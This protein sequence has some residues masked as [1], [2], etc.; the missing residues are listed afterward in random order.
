MKKYANKLKKLFKNGFFFF[1][2]S[3]FLFSCATKNII[4]TRSIDFI[5][6]VWV[7]G[8]TFELG[9]ELGRHPDG[10]VTPISTVMLKGFYISIYPVTQEQYLSV[11]G[12]N[13]SFFTIANGR[14]PATGENDNRRPV[15]NISWYDTIVFCNLLSMKEGLIPAYSILDN[16]D[17]IAW[18][19]VPINRNPDWDAVMIVDGSNGYRLPT[20]AQWEYAAKGGDGSPGNFTFSGSNIHSDVAWYHGNSGEKTHEVGLKAPNNLGIYDMI[21]NVSEWCWDWR[22]GYTSDPKIDPLGG[23]FN[24]NLS[25]VFRGGSWNSDSKN[26]RSVSRNAFIIWDDDTEEKGNTVGFRIVRP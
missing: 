19:T 13:P 12:N 21:G 11:M 15:E 8:G 4:I 26:I 9:K 6:M 18:G 17:P 20:E 14:L 23:E 1:L 22:R 5:E 24:V 10:D 16:S 25:R 7:P 2:V 3:I